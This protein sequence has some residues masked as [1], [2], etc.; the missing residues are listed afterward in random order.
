MENY[1]LNRKIR[2]VIVGSGWRSMYYVRIAKALPERFE[3]GAM[4]CR[5]QEKADAVGT[6]YGIHTTTSPEECKR[7]NPDFVVVAVNKAAIAKVSVEWLHCGFTVLCETPAALTIEDLCALWSLHI[8]SG[9]KLSVAEQYC[10]Y[11]VYQAMLKILSGDLIGAPYNASVSLAHDYHGASLIR[12]FLRAG[13]T[14]FSVWGSSYSFPT[15]E[16]C[17]R[18]ER[19]T[20]G[21]IA[22]K[23]RDRATIVFDDGKA[24]FYDFNPEQYRSPIRSNTVIVQGCRGE[25]KDQTFA[26]LDSSN[27]ACRQSVTVEERVV[28][29][30]DLNPNLDTVTEVQKITFDGAVLYE[31]PFGLCGLSQDETAVAELMADTAAYA[32]G[33]KPLDYPLEQALQD[34]YMGLLMQQAIMRG[35]KVS[36]TVQPWQQPS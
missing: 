18:Y 16:T 27:R 1:G 22:E 36:S 19:F 28:K 2:F 17:S 14:P 30:G 24:A 34:A 9:A 20:D 15:T 12:A 3:L 7:L 31:P 11:P 29:T 35:E 8:R 6:K 13:M 23:K 5:T 10:R 21:R 4:L 32:N 33:I 25:M 26:Y